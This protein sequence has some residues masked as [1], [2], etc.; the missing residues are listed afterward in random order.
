MGQ[1]SGKFE[2]LVLLDNRDMK[3]MDTLLS[4]ENGPR[5][6]VDLLASFHFCTHIDTPLS[7]QLHFK[8]TCPD[9]WRDAMCIH[10]VAMTALT[11]KGFELS[12]ELDERRLPKHRSLQAEAKQHAQRLRT[13]DM[14][15][16]RAIFM[17]DDKSE[18][19]DEE[20]IEKPRM[21][22]SAT[23]AAT[24]SSSQAVPKEV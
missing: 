20:P 16:R 8:C 5:R 22:R 13:K 7:A 21:K 19:D 9:F 14:E 24:P 10:S 11:S 15:R 3:K 18:N 4:V 2:T 17:S 1:P 23:A 12:C 6:L